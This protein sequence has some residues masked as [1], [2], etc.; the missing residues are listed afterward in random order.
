MYNKSQFM[1]AL[2][3]V[4]SEIIN[5]VSPKLTGKINLNIF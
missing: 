5:V 1:F 3:C 2:I 4:T